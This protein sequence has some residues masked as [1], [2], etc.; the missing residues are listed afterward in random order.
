MIAV[1][2]SGGANISSVLFALERLGAEAALTSDPEVIRA[3][4]RVI[5][6]G[7]GAA[8]NAMRLLKDK[9]LVDCIR[10]LTQ[11]VIGICLGMQLLFERSEEGDAEMLGIIPGTVAH[12]TPAPGMTVPHMG[13][14]SV[15]WD[16]PHPL[17]DGIEKDSFFYFVHSYHAPDT[18]HA[19]GLCDYG[20][21][22]PAI[23]AKENFMGCQFHPER[24]GAA[25]AR[26][27]KNFM[28]M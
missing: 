6:P 20:S 23:V 25:G 27:L 1:I 17:L 16:A 18:P 9:G 8:G 4:P 21:P 7:V 10:G 13:W 12:F 3:A 15:T 14:N 26:I 2:D 28:E 19:V 22:F 24:S 11:P 5:L